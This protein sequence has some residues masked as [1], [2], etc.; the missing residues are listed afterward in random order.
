MCCQVIVI[1]LC[2]ILVVMTIMLHR[3]QESYAYVSLPC[4]G[5]ARKYAELSRLPAFKPY[6]C[7]PNPY[8]KNPLSPT[9]SG[10]LQ[11]KCKRVEQMNQQELDDYT[12][13]IEAHV[14]R[15]N[16]TPEECLACVR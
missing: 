12:Y 3:S 7:Y 5:C 14:L 4:M 10:M 6:L 13:F 16:L 15:R 8:L 1:S 9:V 2:L 11:D